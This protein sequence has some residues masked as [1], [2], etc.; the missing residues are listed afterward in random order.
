M[1]FTV[2]NI[3]ECMSDRIRDVLSSRIFD[4]SLKAGDR[5]VELEIAKEFDTS[6]T[7]VREA[8]REL[9]SQRLVE[10][11]PYRGTRVREIRA[12]EMVEAYTVRGALEK[13]AAELAAP[14]LI[15][16][17]KSLR[18]SLERIH[19]AAR[20]MDI[21]GYALHNMNFHRGIVVASE[22]EVLVDLWDRLAFEAR[23]RLQLHRH[24]EPNLVARAYEHDPIVDALEVGD[25]VLAG[26]LLEGHAESCKQR[27]CE[28][29]RQAEIHDAGVECR[30]VKASCLS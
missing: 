13:L 3:R 6:Q 20:E 4:G 5:L 11:A 30:P 16:N 18:E 10:S 29:M 12:R 27:W 8:L 14:R 24:H 21:D 22:N 15:G 7:P 9:E 23:V 1:E 26:N 19:T 28:Q 2:T 25:G 17:V